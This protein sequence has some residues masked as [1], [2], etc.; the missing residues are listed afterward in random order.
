[1]FTDLTSIRHYLKEGIAQS[2]DVFYILSDDESNKLK[3]TFLSMY[4]D[5]SD[6]CKKYDLTLM[7]SSGTAL[8]AVRHKGFIPWDDDFDMM[9]P[10][11]DYQKL[12]EVFDD[13]LSDKYTLFSPEKNNGDSPTLYMKIYKKGTKLAKLG[14]AKKEWQCIDIDI[15]PIDYMPDNSCW[16]Y[17]KCRLLDYIRII[18]VSVNIYHDNDPEYAKA[19]LSSNLIKRL[20][21]RTRWSLGM[22]CSVFGRNRWFMFH[23]TFSS[24]SKESCWCSLPTGEFAVKELQPYNVFFPPRK[25]VFEGLD[26]YIPNDY[27]AYLTQLYGDYM[28]LPPVEK[29]RKHHFSEKPSF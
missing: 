22:I 15:Y 20:F 27:D 14:R 24:S 23:S 1:M 28:Q 26:V 3:Q 10:R 8:G 16:R 12:I 11:K 21:Y 18:A 13:E 4:S 17:L 25:A 29:R 5:I 2:S 9:M 6:V 7:V 19:F